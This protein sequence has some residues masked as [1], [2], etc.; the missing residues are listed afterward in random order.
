M[1]LHI[2]YVL[3][4]TTINWNIQ[5]KPSHLISFSKAII[6]ENIQDE[7]SHPKKSYNI[8]MNMSNACDG[9]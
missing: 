4:K 3:L 7:P 6:K 5:D 8:G 1:N 9:A 2:L